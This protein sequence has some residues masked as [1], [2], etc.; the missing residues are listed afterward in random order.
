MDINQ[1]RKDTPDTTNL[2]HLNNAGASLCPIQV[3]TAIRDYI[4][5]KGSAIIDF[6][7]K[8]IEWVVRVSPHYYNT[9]NEIDRFIEVLKTL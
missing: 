5:T 9:E 2:V 1:I 8:D 7:E 3:T 4:M 6:A